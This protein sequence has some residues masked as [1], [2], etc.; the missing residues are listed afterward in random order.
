MTSSVTFERQTKAL[1]DDLKSVCANYGLGNDGNEFKIIGFKQN[2]LFTDLIIYNKGIGIVLNLKRGELND[3][4]N[5]TEDISDKGHWGNGEYRIW[6]NT[7]EE[8]DYGFSLIK[9]SYKK[10]GNQ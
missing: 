10:Q 3:F 9:Q 6:I 4:Q 8:I 5:L 2:K 7:M 1:I